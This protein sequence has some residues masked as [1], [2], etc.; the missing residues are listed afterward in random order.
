MKNTI[1]VVLASF[2]LLVLTFA[3]C[4]K[5]T[6]NDDQST[7]TCIDSSLINT[8]AIITHDWNPVCGCNGETY[9]NPMAAKYSGVTKYTEGVC[10]HDSLLGC[11]DSSL[12]K[13]EGAIITTEWNPVCGCNGKTYTNPMDAQANGVISYTQGACGKSDEEIQINFQKQ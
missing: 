7:E 10:E 8:Q 12:I 4:E 5:E 6:K 3:S 2:V 11:V 1:T 9:S 13:S